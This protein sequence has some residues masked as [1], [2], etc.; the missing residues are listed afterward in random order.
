VAPVMPAMPRKRKPYVLREV[1]RHGGTAWYFRKGKGP[2]I[3]LHG[4]Y[5]SDEWLADY[6]AALGGQKR[7]KPLTQTGTIGWLI[8][9]YFNSVAFTSAAP[10]T[11]SQRGNILKAVKRD[12][13]ARRIS[14]ITPRK[15]AESRDARSATP[16]Q[17]VVFVK[18]MRALFK[19]AVDAQIVETNPATGIVATDPKTDGH[20]S[21]TAEE[22]EAFR[23][24]HPLGTMAR[25]ALDIMLFLGMRASDTILFGRQHVHGAAVAYRSQKTGVEVD[26]PLLEPLRASIEAVGESGQM[27][28]LLTEFGTPFASVN[29]FGNWFRKRCKEAG[30]PGRA[31]GIRKASAT[32]AA[33]NSATDRELMA[34]YGWTTEKQAGV[35]TRKADRTRLARQAAE[36]LETGTS[37]P[38]PQYPVRANGQ[39]AQ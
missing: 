31:H 29:S 10:A 26:A 25:L 6:E 20:H 22:I 4:D 30:V 32:I 5:E 27:T 19:W 11:Q 33:E 7:V 12:H 16:A 3:R 14:E 28:F 35:Y 13:G 39:K 21:W 18:A 24:R 1:T 36:K 34:L 15:I 9:K 8:D 17:A 2:R 38:A 23:K 37:I